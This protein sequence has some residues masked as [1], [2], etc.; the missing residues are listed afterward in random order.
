MDG[1]VVMTD[2]SI[3]PPARL[4]ERLRLIPGF[5]WDESRPLFHSSYDSWLGSVSDLV[6][7]IRHVFGTRFVSLYAT[8]PSAPSAALS[9]SA[10]SAASP[11]SIAKLTSSRA[12]PA[13]PSA[14]PDANSE[15]PVVSP[16]INAA[17]AAGSA[18]AEEP[19]IARV[20]LNVLREERTFHTSKSLSTTA[21]PEGEHLVKP[22]DLVQLSPQQGDRGVYVVAIYQDPGPNALPKLLDLGP[23]F[24]Y[25]RKGPEG[26]EAYRKGFFE[27]DPPISLQNF[28]DFAIGAT[29]CLEMIHHGLGLT[30]GEIRGDAFHYN[31]ETGKVKLVSFG[32]GLRSFEHGLT[33]TGWSVLSK[34]L[35]AKNKLLYISPE[36]TGRMPAEPDSRTDIYSTGVLFWSLLTQQPVFEGDTALDIV[37]GVLGRRIPNVSAVRL[38]V[39]DALGR[40]IQK[41]TSKNVAERY[42]SAS[43][44]RHDL[45]RVQEFLGGG[46]WLALKEWQIA[47]KDVSSFFMMPAIM[48]GRDKERDQLVQVI[49]RVAKSHSMNHPPAGN[50]FSDGSS[51]SNSN[52]FLDG[53]DVS[54]E[55]ASSGEGGNRRSGSFTQTVSSDPKWRSGLFPSSHPADSQ[56]LSSDTLS[57]G[58]SGTPGFRMPQRAWE[59]HQPLPFDT[60]SLTDSVN[61]G[62]DSGRYSAAMESSAS[63][64]KQLGSAK[65]RR[66]GHCEI[67]TVEGSAGLGKSC[68]V[69]SVLAEAR[70]RGYCATAKFETTRRAPFGPLLKL[71]SSLFRQVWGERNT[72]TPFHQSLKQYVRPL[73]PNLHRVLGLPEFLLGPVEHSVTRAASGSQ[74][75]GWS[76][77]GR[78]GL[79]RRGSSPGSPS[80]L[81]RG[82]K[83]SAPSSEDFLRRGTS[84]KSSRLMNT[85][86][87]L[88]RMFTN[89]KFICFCLDDL[90]FADTESLELITQVISS[91]LKMVIIITYRPEEM[92]A[93][94]VEALVYPPETEEMPRARGPTITKIQLSPL[95]DDELVQYVAATLCKP[96]EDVTGLA[97]V[98]QVKS[99]GNPFLM[100]EMLSAC[101]R[102]KCIWYDYHTSQWHYDVNRVFEQFKGDSNY[103]ILDTDFITGRLNELPP[104]SR[105]ILAW[106]ALLGNAFSFEMVCH[107]LTGEFKYFDEAGHPFSEG[108]CAQVYTQQEAVSG[109][110]AAIQACVITSSET[111]DRFRFAHD[112]YVQAASALKQCNSRAMHFI[113]AQTLMKYYCD[114]VKSREI[115]AFHICESIDI[116]KNQVRERAPYRKLLCECAGLANENGARTSAAKYYSNALAL[117]QPDPWADDG[118]DVSYEE[119]RQLYLRA[120]E[121]YLYMGQHPLTNSTLDMVFKRAK[122][123]MDKAPA[124]VIQSRIFSQ[125]GNSLT[126]LRC[127]KDCLKVLEIDYHEKP[128]YEEC[129]KK[130]EQISAKIKSMDRADILNVTQASDARVSSVGAVLV[131][132]I[133][134]AWWCDCVEFYSLALVMLELH[135]SDGAFPQTGMGFL[136]LSLVALTRFNM[137]QLAVDLAGYAMELIDA[138]RDP[139]SMARGYM[140]FA[141]FIGHVQYP[142][143]T[144]A[145]QLDGSI[146]YAAFAGGRLSA[147]LGAGLAA[148]IKFFASENCA[149]LEAFCQ[150]ACE[151]VPNW[152]QDARGGTLLIAVRQ[153]CRA[154]QG[155]TNITSSTDM[156]CDD[157]HNTVSYKTWLQGKSDNGLRALAFYNSVEIV[158]LYL[159]GF[160]ERAAEVGKNCRQNEGLLWSARNTQLAAL[161]Y[162]LALAGLILRKE[163]DPRARPDDD[164]DQVRETI[165]EL[166]AL[167]QKFLDWSVVTDVNYLAWTRLLEAQIAELEGDQGRAIRHYEEALD[168]A[169]EHEFVFEEALGNYLMAGIFVRHSARRSAR[170]AL[171][172]AIALYRQMGATGIAERI[173]R[174]HSLL[175]HGPT[176]NPRT[177]EVGVQTDFAGDAPSGQYR[178][179]EVDGEEDHLT[180][181]AAQVGMLALKGERL[182]AWRGT[183]QPEAGAG[184]PAL[185]MIDLHA[186]LQSSQVISSVLQ[187]EELLKTMCDV[188]LQTCGGSA[189]LAAIVVQDEGNTEWCVA[190]SGDPERGAEAHK[191]GI[192]LTGTSLVAENV[193]LYSTRFREAVFIADLINDERFGNVSECWLQ[194]NPLSKAVI[195]I[196]ICHGSKPLLGVLYLEGLPGSFTDRNVTVLQ[197]LV[198]QIGISYSNALSM[199]AVEKVSAENVSMVALQK[200]ALHKA[201]EAENKAKAAEQEAKRNVQLAE[202]AEAEAK[203]NVKLA[204]EA[205]KAK[206]IFLA[207]VSHELRTPLNGVIGNSELLRD[208][209]LTSEQQE[210]AE[211]IRLSADLLLTVIND[212]LDFSRME[213]DKMKLYV[214]AFNPK[215]MVQ[216]VV[217]AVSYRNQEKTSQGVVQIIK[218]INLPTDMLVY[219]DPVRLHQVLGNLIGNSLKFTE[220]GSITIGARVDAETDDKA[221]MTF[222][223]EDTGIGIPP[224]QLAKLFQPFSQADPSTAR[225]YG[226]SGLGLS[227]CKSLIETIMKGR[228]YLDSKENVGTRAWFTVTFDKA[229]PEVSAGDAQTKPSQQLLPEI[230]AKSPPPADGMTF[231]RDVSPNPFLDLSKIPKSE[232]RVCIAEDNPI[233]RKIAIQY[234]QRLGYN[235]VD[236]YDNGL[237]A[238]EALRQKAKDGEPYHVILM[239]V[240]MPVLDGYEATK[241]LRQDPIE[242]VRDILVI[243]MTASAIQGDREKCLAAGM[244]DYLAKPVKSDVLKKKLDTYIGA[245][246]VSEDGVIPSPPLNSQTATPTPLAPQPIHLP[247]HPVPNGTSSQGL[248]VPSNNESTISST[249]PTNLSRSSSDNRRSSDNGSVENLNSAPPAK[250]QPRKLTKNR[251][252]SDTSVTT[253]IA[254]PSP[255]TTPAPSVVQSERSRPGVLQK[256]NHS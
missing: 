181:Q 20:S 124:Y 103:E 154:L 42:Q 140:I 40:I 198:N 76:K 108:P 115:A 147:I 64:S 185:D 38:D 92:S 134:A 27:L 255:S 242:A 81:S 21:D 193:V 82:Q 175:L 157:Q 253:V 229:R 66:R 54:S 206:S 117:L 72:E 227:I 105:S 50:R 65:F 39:P 148:Q 136:H 49:E 127:L 190:A 170:S 23:A 230:S 199:K 69:Q 26:Y 120:A 84:T 166:E 80:S 46:D 247:L 35:G 9:P 59:R 224:A 110:Q 222:W 98:I 130:F 97:M 33:S 164:M 176:R 205:A 22:I 256:R 15:V 207:N 10:N 99:A 89:H 47:S 218:Q 221:T 71:L 178:A 251:G 91:R 201:I 232:L 102:K 32:S 41:C 240:Q 203:R 220:K 172:D 16:P 186:I 133:S 29:Q 104:A 184:L 88:L 3:D 112:R 61:T 19:I 125:N 95:T 118:E 182:G 161:F 44:L 187:V 73:W 165:K 100:R 63:L 55:G 163:Q 90:H 4:F 208:S 179:V 132:A 93:E 17:D 246:P 235:V 114:D 212:I 162:G 62:S 248:P 168:H 129:D 169:S 180:D 85:F 113:I 13:D 238:V 52:E 58:N 244:N 145:A 135:F 83:L 231:D 189:T 75:S 241:L 18:L 1:S 86:L 57:S 2:E 173:E 74:S 159:Y 101:Y 34:E 139:F 28:L 14:L 37:Q 8:A 43:G 51:L 219:G 138:F 137:V 191:P 78:G 30:H 228:I 68:L 106:A 211:S 122:T 11:S 250:R 25:A 5:A 67:V 116:I 151:D 195:A 234:V 243:A 217:R 226:G 109:L 87:D 237:K 6:T 210:M 94:Q 12:S 79:R 141:N 96:K 249:T 31:V 213:A 245:Q 142:I 70:R 111:D 152:H 77:S 143:S 121:C 150:F 225:K 119:T 126:A 155:K 174:E 194:R 192:P 254:V 123:P 209:N 128:T 107:L 146:E 202:E 131:E 149:D 171:R 233:N 153:V 204:E 223:V 239:D 167:K 197:L 60:R 236:A 177:T 215:E 45:V 216:E 56:T 36:Q 156:M 48:I 53:A 7:L 214:I 144:T 158:P 24:Y 183:M 252:N 196:P 160:Y 188:I 200:R